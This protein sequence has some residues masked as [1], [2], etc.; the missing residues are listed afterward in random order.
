MA[1]SDQRA[2]YQHSTTTAAGHSAL[3]ADEH[4]HPRK[5]PN[6]LASHLRRDI[7]RRFVSRT[8]MPIEHAEKVLIAHTPKILR[9]EPAARSAERVRCMDHSVGRHAYGPQKRRR[10]PDWFSCAQWARTLQSTCSPATHVMLCQAKRGH[11]AQKG[12]HACEPE[13]NAN[14]THGHS[15]NAPRREG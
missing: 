14:Q 4:H 7:I 2:P 5:A 6:L 11:A 10:R 15:R 1:V 12:I 3:A 8:A 13:S 9:T